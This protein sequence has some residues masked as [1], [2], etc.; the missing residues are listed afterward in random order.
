MAQKGDGSLTVIHRPV[1]VKE[2]SGLQTQMPQFA[3]LKACLVPGN[4][5]HGAGPGFVHKGRAE[6]FEKRT[7][8]RRVMS[9]H[10]TGIRGEGRHLVG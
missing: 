6:A 9:N 2:K 1:P 3:P 10:Q 4:V 7:V 8:K 5:F